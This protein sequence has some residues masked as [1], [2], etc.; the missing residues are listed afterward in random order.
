MY[1]KSNQSIKHIKHIDLMKTT[2][3][4]SNANDTT[5]NSSNCA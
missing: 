2:Q 1:N 3:I 5:A 4:Q